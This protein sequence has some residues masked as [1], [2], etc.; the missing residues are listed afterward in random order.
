MA[1]PHH[2]HQI[3]PQFT[4]GWTYHSQTWNHALPQEATVFHIINPQL[5]SVWHFITLHSYFLQF[6]CTGV[7]NSFRP[8]FNN[9]YRNR[10]ILR[11]IQFPSGIKTKFGPTFCTSSISVES[12]PSFHPTSLHGHELSITPQLEA[13]HCLLGFEVRAHRFL[14]HLVRAENKV[15]FNISVAYHFSKVY[16]RDDFSELVWRLTSFWL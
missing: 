1:C 4:V 7:N 9:K 11:N 2:W 8:F 16:M 15:N 6:P 12:S 14:T 13:G 3:N 5:P 10:G